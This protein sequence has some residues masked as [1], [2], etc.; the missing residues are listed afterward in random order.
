M[1]TQLLEKSDKLLLS[2]KDI[3]RLLSISEESAKVSA[4]RY[5]KASSLSRLKKDTYILTSK[6]KTLTEVELFSIANLIQVPS[7]ISLTSALS[8]FDISTQIVRGAVES[9]AVKRSKRVAVNNYEFIFSLVKKNFYAGFERREGI[10][11]A[12]PEKALADAVYLS[13][14]GK[15]NA[16]F[17]AIDF[18][19]TK[20]SQV[21]RFIDLTNLKTQKYWEALCKTFN[22]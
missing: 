10:F 16:D 20:L 15:Y 21:D 8:Y 12:S 3:S 18:K 19:K 22:L 5:V 14:I 9:I 13:S 6:L 2:I 17:Y 1:K 7:Y 11:I 4:V